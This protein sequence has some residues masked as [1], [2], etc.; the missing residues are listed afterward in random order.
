MSQI[1]RYVF[2]L[3][4]LIAILVQPRDAAA[5]VAPCTPTE[6]AA[7]LDELRSGGSQPVALRCS[8]TLDST[9][10]ITHP[11]YF[12]GSQGSN[13]TLYCN[14]AQ[15]LGVDGSAMY[16]HSR[17]I[18]DSQRRLVG[19]EQLK[20]VTIVGCDIY[21]GVGIIGWDP[22]EVPT[23]GCAP[24]DLLCPL[25]PESCACWTEMK[26]MSR[27]SNF[28]NT[29]R[30][31]SPTNI[32][33]DGVFISAMGTPLYIY[34]GST[35]VTVE[36]S[37][38]TGAGDGPGIYLDHE[39]AYN[40]IHNNYIH[41]ASSNR[42]QI[43]IDGSER[44]RI[45]DNYFL[46]LD[47]GGIYLYRNCG[48]RGVIRHTTPSYNEIVNNIFYY[49]EYTGP[50]PSIDIGSRNGTST[51]AGY[52]GDDQGWPYGSSVDNLDYA[53]YNT[54]V[55]NQVYKRTLS[56][57][58]LNRWPVTNSQNVV[59][60]NSTVTNATVV[61]RLA[62]CYVPT[63]YGSDF[64]LHGQKNNVF[65]WP[66]GSPSCGWSYMCNDGVF[67]QIASYPC[68]M[69][70]IGFEA[71]I[72][73]N[74]NGVGGIAYCP[75]GKRVIGATAVCNLEYGTVSSSD[76]VSTTANRIRV[77]VPSS[78][79]TDGRCTV[80]SS[81]TASPETTIVGVVGATQ[82]S[83]SCFERDSNGGDCHILGEIYCQ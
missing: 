81:Y 67:Q 34:P 7:A 59:R 73:G 10:R 18:E 53:Q 74:N 4:T 44:N 51:G 3:A 28:V 50:N 32:R 79:V 63:M 65:K 46:E 58:L 39:S 13:V 42:E 64:L 27:T 49:D 47:D 36:S 24:S 9:D 15:I 83:Y 38:I 21:G 41:Y 6:T 12:L 69:S 16:L 1:S 76:L 77:A 14:G 33:L 68:P 35:Y 55:Q 70:R 2:A 17:R 5:D 60:Y 62:G 29:V 78:T 45:V 11:I 56:S 66:N 61:S 19:Y 72:E 80:G 43:A 26:S 25:G 75:A 22:S 71:R 8:V 30:A 31:Q 52:C 48:E 54:V 82:V 37:E 23:S 20:N 40:Y 57:M